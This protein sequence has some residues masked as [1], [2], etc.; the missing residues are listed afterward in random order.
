M[1]SAHAH[2]SEVRGAGAVTTAADQG[3]NPVL[4]ALPATP[5]T[6]THRDIIREQTLM[7]TAQLSAS[8]L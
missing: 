7:L 8:C 4:T 5:T 3:L 1:P 2:A 6:S